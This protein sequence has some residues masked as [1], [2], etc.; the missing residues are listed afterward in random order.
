M[1]CTLCPAEVSDEMDDI[2]EAI[3]KGWIPYFYTGEE[4]KG[5]CCAECTDK[6]LDIG[7]DGEW[8]L[9]PGYEIKGRGVIDLEEVLEEDPDYDPCPSP[10]EN[11]S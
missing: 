5:C 3:D 11:W 10:I 7:E 2:E 6:Y 8:Q 1:E 4:E 9:Q